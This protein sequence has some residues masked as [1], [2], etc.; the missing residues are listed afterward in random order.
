M[1]L[2]KPNMELI[3]LQSPVR[4][5]PKRDTSKEGGSPRMVLLN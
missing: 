3:E 5:N 2:V 4:K 1:Q